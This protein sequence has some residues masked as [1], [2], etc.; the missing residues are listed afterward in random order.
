MTSTSAFRAYLREVD[1]LA[2]LVAEG[3]L[4]R[5]RARESQEA[6]RKIL[7]TRLRRIF[8]ERLDAVEAPTVDEQPSA[9]PG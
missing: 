2:V 4:S 8:N 1:H 9:V 5:H 7:E 3:R 6:L